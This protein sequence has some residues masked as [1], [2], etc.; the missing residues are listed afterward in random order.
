VRRLLAVFAVLVVG[1]AASA[2][3]PASPREYLIY[4]L[5]LLRARSIDR[6]SLDW[7]EV[8]ADA[9]HLAAGVSD[10][11]GTYSAIRNVIYHLGN[12][13]TRLVGP[14]AAVPPP[15]ATIDLPA[16]RTSGDVAVLTIPQ[17]KADPVGERR[18]IAA[19]VAAVAAAD[20]RGPCGWIADLR[21]NLGGDMVPMLTVVAP[22]LDEGV[23]GS[24]EGTDGHSAWT[25]QAGRVLV[26]G[27][28]A[29][30][31]ANPLRLARPQPPVAVLT[32]GQ[33]ASS[34]EATLVAFRGLSRT[35]SFGQATAGFATG[36]EAHQLSDGAV[37]IITSARD[38]D[39]TGR[40]YGNTPIRPD[41]PLPAAATTDQEVA[42]ATA[43]LHTQAGCAHR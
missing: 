6:D 28:P 18:Y 17:F 41:H 30:D 32:D 27:R 12:P 39:R 13:H 3:R 7:P 29:I 23:L 38:A 2:P 35:A 31:P 34:G 24:F 4:A 26:P 1:L 43:W 21:G 36:N 5:S 42:A 37:L 22:L 25:L 40:V 19:G 9:L 20:S 16:S 8:E 11:A 10:P 14:A 33:T 15:P